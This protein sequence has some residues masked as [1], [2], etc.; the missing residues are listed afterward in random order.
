MSFHATTTGHIELLDRW[1]HGKPAR[2]DWRSRPATVIVDD[3]DG[4][5]TAWAYTGALRDAA[6]VAAR[7]DMRNDG[8]H[9]AVLSGNE[10]SMEPTPDDFWIEIDDGFTPNTARYSNVVAY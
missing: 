7:F 3:G 10:V 1:G 5:Y 9:V 6:T 4:H 8:R 2:G